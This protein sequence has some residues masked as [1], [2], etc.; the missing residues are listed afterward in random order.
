MVCGDKMNQAE[1]QQAKYQQDQTRFKITT[2]HPIWLCQGQFLAS[3]G[4]VWISKLDILSESPG[5]CLNTGVWAPLMDWV[6]RGLY[7][8]HLSAVYVRQ[9]GREGTD[10]M[11]GGQE[12]TSR[13]LPLL[14]LSF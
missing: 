10:R 6:C 9:R 3:D 14:H 13:Y 5:V 12:L 11:R 8:E 1:Q 2:N 4:H 7:S